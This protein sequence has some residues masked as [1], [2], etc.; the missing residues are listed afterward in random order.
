[1]AKKK[2]GIASKAAQRV[3]D[4]KAQEKALL[5]AKVVKPVVEEPKVEIVEEKKSPVKE[6]TEV[7]ETTVKKEAKGKKKLESRG[8]NP[9]LESAPKIEGEV[10]KVEEPKEVKNTKATRAKKEPAAPKKSKVKKAEAKVEDTVNVVDVDVAELLKKEVLELNG[11][12]EPV[13]EEK[14]KTKTTSKKKKGLESAPKK[15]TKIE[16]EVVKTEEPKEVKS[17][18]ATRAK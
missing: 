18:K 4:K 9:G 15:R 5:D 13:K 12:V 1:M 11:A 17:A 14:P 8:S 7:V 6:E 2:S 16:G 10:A 3:A